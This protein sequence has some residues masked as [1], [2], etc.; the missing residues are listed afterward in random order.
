[1]IQVS[2]T[3]EHLVVTR[4]SWAE[5]TTLECPCFLDSIILYFM[6][7]IC[8]IE[9]DGIIEQYIEYFSDFSIQTLFVFVWAFAAL[10]ENG[11]RFIQ[12]NP[13]FAL[14]F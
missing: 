1:M 4:K 10:R 5:P 3:R 2:Q 12:Q 14:P 11:R 9:I 6:V 8:G 7:T 13:H